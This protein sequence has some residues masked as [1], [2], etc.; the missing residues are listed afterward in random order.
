MLTS[1]LRVPPHV[2]VREFPAETVLLNI[3]T[4]QYHGLDPVA[5]RMLEAI[6]STGS[7]AEALDTLRETF[8]SVD[9]EILGADL[10]RF[11]ED[12]LARGL[13]ERV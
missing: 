3:R 2:V 10:E 1:G 7:L 8:P 6:G 5:G 4:G 13:L 9:R 12:L 11:S